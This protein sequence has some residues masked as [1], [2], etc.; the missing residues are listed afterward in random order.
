MHIGQRAEGKPGFRVSTLRSEL[1]GDRSGFARLHG[2][3]LDFCSERLAGSRE[4]AQAAQL[5]CGGRE[6]RK[7]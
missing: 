4:D 3:D 6:R 2:E 5:G 7:R 1:P